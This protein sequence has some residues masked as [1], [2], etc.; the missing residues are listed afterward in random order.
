MYYFFN[1]LKDKKYQ[2]N[3]KDTPSSRH[4]HTRVCIM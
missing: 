1:P 2:R 4:R 3:E